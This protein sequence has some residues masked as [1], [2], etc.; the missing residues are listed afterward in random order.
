MSNVAIGGQLKHPLNQRVFFKYGITDPSV[1]H[2]EME[3]HVC[4]E[5]MMSV[6]L[7]RHAGDFWKIHGLYSKADARV[8][9]FPL[10]HDRSR[11]QG[12][13]RAPLH[14][15]QEEAWEAQEWEWFF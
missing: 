11:R 3:R 1:V 9:A 2:H 6:M 10:L 8:Q 14:R 5:K 15:L 13:W 4:S 12:K 7:L